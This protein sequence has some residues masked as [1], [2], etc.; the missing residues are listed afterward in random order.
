MQQMQTAPRP[1][2]S[3]GPPGGMNG[4]PS[5][6]GAIRPL[7]PPGPAGPPG[8]RL[9]IHSVKIQVIVCNL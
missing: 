5:G 2:Y 6:A 3:L 7:G 1:A 8:A 4:P 9:V